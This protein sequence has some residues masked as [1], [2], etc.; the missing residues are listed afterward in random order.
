MNAPFQHFCQKKKIVYDLDKVVRTHREIIDAMQI[1]EREE[2]I[3]HQ[4]VKFQDKTCFTSSLA[5]L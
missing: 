4:M 2:K 5:G 1:Q 3:A